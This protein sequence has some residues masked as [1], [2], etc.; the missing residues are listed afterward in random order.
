VDGGEFIVVLF[1][2]ME[3]QMAQENIPQESI[4][5]RSQFGI[6]SLTLDIIA[7]G[8]FVIDYPALV[9]TT[10]HIPVPLAGAFLFIIPSAIMALLGLFMDKQK[11]LSIIGL[12]LSLISGCILVGLIIFVIYGFTHQY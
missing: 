6:I 8:M 4:F 1:H 9:C 12:I 5:K 3:E 7:V 11:A 10:T 2:E